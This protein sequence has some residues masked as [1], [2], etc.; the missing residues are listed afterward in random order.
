[1]SRSRAALL[2]ITVAAALLAQAAGAQSAPEAVTAEEETV[3][4]QLSRE[5]AEQAGAGTRGRLATRVLGDDQKTGGV[6][7]R[8]QWQA[9]APESILGIAHDDVYHFFYDNE[10]TPPPVE[11]SPWLF[12]NPGGNA[13]PICMNLAGYLPSGPAIDFADGV[14]CVNDNGS[15]QNEVTVAGGSF[16][17]PIYSLNATPGPGEYTWAPAGASPIAPTLHEGN[18]SPGNWPTA[19]HYVDFSGFSNGQFIGWAGGILTLYS[20]NDTS[21][22]SGMTIITFLPSSFVYPPVSVE[23]VAAP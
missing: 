10:P 23:Y 21:G 13:E 4:R 6:F 2:A 22:N 8:K 1:M 11:N 17:M 9:L 20:G 14:G 19:T 18:P 12:Y 3:L 5:T 16:Q 15:G 7:T